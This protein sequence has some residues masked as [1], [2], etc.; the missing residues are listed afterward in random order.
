MTTP[1]TYRTRD[2]K[3]FVAASESD[4]IRQMH[5]D[6]RLPCEDDEAFVVR[7]SNLCEATDGSIVRVDTRAHFVSDLITFGF[8]TVT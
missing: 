7:T 5:A 1:T 8:L 2:G 6:A 3:V 4:L